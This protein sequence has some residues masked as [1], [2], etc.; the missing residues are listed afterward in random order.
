[1]ASFMCAASGIVLNRASRS[2]SA[3]TDW[4]K[5]PRGGV[6]AGNGARARPVAEIRTDENSV[7]ISGSPL[8]KK[9]AETYSASF[10]PVMEISLIKQIWLYECGAR[11]AAY[12]RWIS[13][14]PHRVRRSRAESSVRPSC[15]SPSAHSGARG[16]FG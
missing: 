2:R 12:Q 4:G 16:L 8:R 6:S 11:D 14:R 1:M 15:Q 3:C 5:K 10:G 9:D 7:R 13:Q